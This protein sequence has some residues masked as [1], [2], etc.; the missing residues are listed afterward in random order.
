MEV[1]IHPNQEPGDVDL[2]DRLVVWAR[3]NGA[4][5]ISTE[6]ISDGRPFIATFRY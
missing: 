6:S 1:E 4:E 3:A 2:L 5:I